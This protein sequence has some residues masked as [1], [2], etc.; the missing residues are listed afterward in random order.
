MVDG[1]LGARGLAAVEG[2]LRGFIGAAFFS[3]LDFLSSLEIECIWSVSP[4][5]SV[6]DEAI[7]ATM[8]EGRSTMVTDVSLD[9]DGR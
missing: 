6:D 5:D 9:V 8:G 3:F 4:C 2:F 7:G 1:D